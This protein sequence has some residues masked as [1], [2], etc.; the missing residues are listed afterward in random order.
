MYGLNEGRCQPADWAF[1]EG[2]LPSE[3]IKLNAHGWQ[4]GKDVAEHDHAIRLK[5]PPG[6]E[7]QLHGY[8]SIL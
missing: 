8:F 4:R 6:L 3:N 1:Y 5:G 2:A 7:G